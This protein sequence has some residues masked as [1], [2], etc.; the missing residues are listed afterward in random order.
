[1]ISTVF[2]NATIVDGTGAE[3]YITDVGVVEDR[4]A[5]I[6]NLSQQDAVKRIDCTGKI[7][8]PGFIDVHSHS[9]ETWLALPRCDSKIAQ[10]VTTEIGGNCGMSAAPLI[11]TARERVQREAAHL[12]IDLAWENLDQF[13][14]LVERNRIAL[15]VATLVGLGTTRAAIAGHDDRKLDAA[16]M[17][18]Q[19]RLVREAVGHG[20]IGISSGLIYPPSSYAD[21]D[22]LIAMSRTARESGA[23]LYASHVRNEGDTLLEAIEE[24]IGIGTAADVAVQ[25]SHHKAQGKHN[26]GKVHR[27]LELIDRARTRGVRVHADIYPYVASW[28]DLAT[29]LPADVRTGG[30]IAALARLAD[31]KC[32]TAVALALSLVR[33]DA[34]DWHDILI[35]EV[36]SQRNGQVAGMR[37]DEIARHW[38]LSPARAAL[39]LLVEEEFEVGAVFFS[40]NEDDVSTVL[41]AEFTCIG[42]DASARGLDGITARGIPHPRAFGCFP[43]IYGRYVRER[44]TL[45][46]EAAVHRMT[47]LPAQIFTLHDRGTIGVGKHADLVLFDEQTVRDTATYEHP[48]T[49]PIGIDQ[50]WVNGSAVLMGGIFTNAR[51][52]KVL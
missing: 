43:R 7:L 10:G 38:R 37:M 48:Y 35:T 34:S 36:G 16:D 27:S 46:L 47:G 6:G 52:G 12:K 15:N 2:A 13:F 20:A 5:L 8:A 4:I 19:G 29:I 18:A 11:G 17:A 42:S 33:P 45:Q 44:H 32:L 3:R 31:D 22:E 50:V 24:A 1:M 49:F 25:C 23:P 51:P 9:D 41:S 14:S 39:R 28:T 40:M 26:W 21:R 30:A